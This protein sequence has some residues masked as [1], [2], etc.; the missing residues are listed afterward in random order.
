[1]RKIV[2]IDMDNVLVDFPSAFPH[3]DEAVLAQHEEHRDDIP[4]IFAHM[5]PVEGAVEAFHALA[6]AYE[7]YIL[8]TAPWN[9]P[10]AWSDKL[11]W[12]KEYLGEKAFKRLILTHHKDLNR[13]D[14]L[15]DDREKNGALEFQGELIR[16]KSERFPDWKSVTKYLDAFL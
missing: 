6:E 1:M 7:V 14:Y 12:V 5:Q 2:Y 10:S 4:G 9:N 3:I 8:S 13:G 15:I 16:F 11:E